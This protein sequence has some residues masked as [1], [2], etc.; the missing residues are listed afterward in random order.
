MLTTPYESG[1]WYIGPMAPPKKRESRVCPAC[2]ATFEV[3]PFEKKRYCSMACSHQSP[4]VLQGLCI[5]HE[6]Q[7]TN[8]H[9]FSDETRA[10]MSASA[11]ARGRTWWKGDDVGYMA[12]HRWVSTNFDDPGECFF[13]HR[14]GVLFHW[15]Q[16]HD[17]PKGRERDSWLRL[18][19]KC[20]NHYDRCTNAPYC[21]WCG[22]NGIPRL[23]SNPPTSR[24]EHA[25]R[26]KLGAEKRWRG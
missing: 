26:G 3:R 21:R 24:E 11:K 1:A 17:R 12:L 2:G 25:R 9:G 8:P 18:C 15:A 10:K 4:E 7:R 20:H 5:G 23:H 22:E 14:R 13:C 19:V 16:R 6:K